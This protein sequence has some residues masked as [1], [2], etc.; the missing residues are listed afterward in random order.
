LGWQYTCWVTNWFDPDALPVRLLLFAIMLLAL[1]MAAAIPQAFGERGLLFAACY[2]SIQVGRSLCA[3]LLLGSSHA[4]TPNFR[5]ILGWTSIAAVF[6]I[7][8]GLAS[9]HAR[10][11]LWTVAVACEYGSPMIGFR[12]PWLGRSTTRDWAINGAHLAE[13][14][15]LF[16]IVALGESILVTGATISAS[17]HWEAPTAIAFLVAF[18]GALAMWWI[19]FNMGSRDG[20]HLI[21]HSDDPGRIGAYFHY[22]HVV[23]LAGV[24]VTAVGNDLFIAHPDGHIEAKYVAVLI[25]GPAL[26]LIGNG[27]Y[28]RAIYGRFPLSHVIGLALLA[29]T[30][31]FAWLTDLLMVG[32]LDT[33]ILIATAAW[34]TVSRRRSRV[35][36]AQA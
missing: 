16:V 30:V 28:K 26:Y 24:I 36:A 31:P 29:L 2:A 17:A 19:Y 15:Q 13:R 8:G 27:L 20:A 12:L 22:V 21:E 7:A 9:E 35:L 34:E 1:L 6:W 11:A 18:A 3:V 14:C 25:G 5:R 32:A 33:L 10:L 4:L 23:L